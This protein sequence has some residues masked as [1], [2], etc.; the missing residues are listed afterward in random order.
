[1]ITKCPFANTNQRFFEN[2][3]KFPKHF[4]HQQEM[5]GFFPKIVRGPRSQDHAFYK[6]CSFVGI[7]LYSMIFCTNTVEYHDLL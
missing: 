4:R 7:L 2:V 6:L 5:S 3:F 1:M